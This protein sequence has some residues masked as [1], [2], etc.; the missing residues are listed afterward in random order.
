M[1][2]GLYFGSFNPVTY[3][4]SYYS[5]SYNQLYKPSASLVCRFPSKSLKISSSLLNEYHRL[6]LIK[7][8][9]E[10]ENK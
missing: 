3:R 1:K 9:I 7:S 10:E 6:H 2:I 4:T 5:Q 8:A